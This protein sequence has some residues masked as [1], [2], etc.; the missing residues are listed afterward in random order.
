M[1]YLD[2]DRVVFMHFSGISLFEKYDIEKISRHQNRYSLADFPRMRAVL[3]A[4][5]TRV[6]SFKVGAFRKIRYGYNHF[7]NG[8]AVPSFFRLIYKEIADTVNVLAP[9]QYVVDRK[10]LRFGHILP[11]AESK[12]KFD[13]DNSGINSI[14]QNVSLIDYLLGGP[15]DSFVDM[16][17]PQ[18]FSELEQMVYNSRPDLKAAFPDVR[19]VHY[20]PYKKWAKSNLVLEKKLGNYIGELWHERHLK[21][22]GLNSK[23]H[24]GI[25]VIGWVNGV[26]GV[27]LSAAMIFE[28]IRSTGVPVD[29]IYPYN[30]ENHKHIPGRVPDAVITRSPAKPINVIVMNADNTPHLREN[31]PRSL[32]SFHYNVGVWAWELDRFPDAWVP[33]LEDFDE[34]WVPSLFIKSSIESSSLYGVFRTPVVVMPFGYEFPSDA[35]TKK[36]DRDELVVHGKYLIKSGTFLFLTMFDYQSVFERKNP[37]G[38]VKAFKE[39]FSVG[40]TVDVTLLVKSSNY[41][42]IYA[43]SR[44]ALL[45]AIGGDP[46][47]ILIEGVHL[48]EADIKEMYQR[49][50]CYVSLHRSEGFGLPILQAMASLTP[51]IATDYSGSSDFFSASPDVR[52]AHFPISYK[53]V[54]VQTISDYNPYSVIPDARWAEP[55]HQE[56]VDAMHA[57]VKGVS[58]ESLKLA[59]SALKEKFGSSAVGKRIVGRLTD[60]VWENRLEPLGSSNIQDSHKRSVFS[61]KRIK[62]RTPF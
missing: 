23:H 12:W 5:L 33:F 30:A 4:Y 58:Q 6:K 16:E 41:D 1:P 51:T 49:C 39:A 8:K 19:G 45:Q 32:W 57:A 17:T 35:L 42:P 54:S 15:Y 55:N 14:W 29:V 24:F 53:E 2:N 56:A 36:S 47:I 31:Y 20:A 60:S 50:D 62:K 44:D 37:V 28:S 40:S 18:Y 22:K 11:F 3:Q 34:I 7:D 46:R 61:F 25:S 26:F 21:R 9:H 27:G 38:S 48:S 52:A 43:M 13:K 59:R 10:W